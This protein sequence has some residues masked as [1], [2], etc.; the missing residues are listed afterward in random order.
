MALHAEQNAIIYCDREDLAGAVIY[1]SREPCAACSKLIEGAGIT[2][3]HYPDG[4][5]FYGANYKRWSNRPLWSYVD[6]KDGRVWIEEFGTFV[7]SDGDPH[8]F[9][10]R[11][12][13]SMRRVTGLIASNEANLQGDHVHQHQCPGMRPRGEVPPPRASGS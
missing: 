8:D 5:T 7:P 1:V 3:A 4:A 11:Q 9:I 6:N 10:K 13:Q 12:Q 2:E